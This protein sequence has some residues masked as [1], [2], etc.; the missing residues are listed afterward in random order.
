MYAWA[1]AAELL[2]VH[3]SKQIID[4]ICGPEQGLENSNQHQPESA[5]MVV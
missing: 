2:N 3:K 1:P 5:G 4:E